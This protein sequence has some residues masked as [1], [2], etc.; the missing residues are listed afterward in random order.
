MKTL[1]SLL[2]KKFWKTTLIFALPISLQNLL[3]SS[4]AIV[5]NIMVNKI[6]DEALSAVGMAGQVSFMLN[7]FLF[8]I[9]S[10]GL[11]FAAQFW[12]SKN[13]SGIK[14]VYG[15]VVGSSVLVA[16]VFVL[17]A[18]IMP[19]TLIGLFTENSVIIDYGVKYIKIASYSYFGIA[20]NMAA[21]TI[22]RSTEKVILPMITSFISVL[23]NVVLNY[24]FI[25]GKL[26]LP[27]MGIEGA[28]LATV[29]SA[30]L[31][32][33]LLYTISIFKRNILISNPLEMFNINKQTI[34]SFFKR[35]LPVILNE[36]VWAIGI[37]CINAMFGRISPDDNYKAYTITK[38]VENIVFVFF[39]GI[40]NACAVLVGKFIG[41]DDHEKAKDYSKRYLIIYPLMGL[42]LGALII[43]FRFPI[44]SLYESNDYVRTTAGWLVVIYGL[45]VSLRNIPYIGIV[46]IF[47]AGGDTKIGMKFDVLTL[48]CFSL[49]VAFLC[50]FVFKLPFLAVYLIML[51][52][53]DI[54]KTI[55]VLKHYFSMK[56]L[57]PVESE[58]FD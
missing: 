19:E 50:A 52:C 1:K 44:L 36:S 51:L 5:D 16:G 30:F 28:A 20:L 23:A 41:E 54:P 4:F 29:I 14:K 35:A 32:P 48:W 55:L 18:Q 9:T 31:N 43:A 37:L 12:G 53:E 26:G 15:M 46:G 56:W 49:P 21:S 57:I 45:E 33:V 3:M 10:G 7:M 42:V 11:V 27:E 39:V 8:G 47:R 24:G 6:A 2:D 40:C 22:L 58:N 38:N 17:L 25:F 13:L 34:I